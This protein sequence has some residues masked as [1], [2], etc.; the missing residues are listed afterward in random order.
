MTVSVCRAPSVMLIYGTR[1]EA[2]KMA[3]VVRELH[4][5]PHFA[6]LVVLTGQH[7]SMLDQLNADFGIT[8]DHNLEIMAVGQSLQHITSRSLDGVS[9]I[10]AAERPDLVMVQG[11]T[12][13]AFAGA[14]AAFYAQ[15]PVAHLEAG[16]RT[17][18]I[19]SPYPE[20]MNRRLTTRLASLHLVPTPASAANLLRENVDRDSI[21]VTGN[22]VIDS[23]LWTVRRNRPFAHPRLRE[24]ERSGAPVLLV[25]AHRRESWGEP[26]RRVAQALVEISWRLPELQ[27]VLPAHR[28]P[29]VREVLL[30]ALERGRNIDVLEPLPYPDFTRLMWLSK[31]VLTDSG[32]VQEEAPSL[33]KPVLVM[34]ESTE[35]PEGLT[36]GTARLVGTSPDVIVAAVESLVRNK[37]AYRA[38]ARAVNPYG[39]G[40]AGRRSVEAL[41]YFFRQGPAPCEFTPP[42][43]S[44]VCQDDASRD[45]TQ[46]AFPTASL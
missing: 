29:I 10:I 32:G 1:P 20:E 36:A 17:D 26:M 25:T 40:E 44:D 16:L 23:L 28:N 46:A 45:D 39:D 15:V 18:D 43:A 6:P 2:I 19:Y 14:L 8:A 37:A 27:I 30:P 38:M 3:P 5:S 7:A 9:K 4:D 12:T 41:A 22:T 35:R 42:S 31:L 11:D 24:I 34:R 13:S 21:L 33:G